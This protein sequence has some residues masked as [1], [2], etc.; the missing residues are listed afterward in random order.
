MIPQNLSIGQRGPALAQRQVGQTPDLSGQSALSS[1][2][3]EGTTGLYA[4][5]ADIERLV[6]IV[7]MHGVAYPALCR[8]AL[9]TLLDRTEALCALV[10]ASHFDDASVAPVHQ[11]F[12]AAYLAAQEQFRDYARWLLDYAVFLHD[13]LERVRPPAA[14][15]LRRH[16]DA[17]RTLI[18][19]SEAIADLSHT[20][21]LASRLNAIV[22]P[23]ESILREREG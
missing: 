23:A 15:R 18:L 20:V 16:L 13:Q 6:A 4:T 14:R 17:L 2:S 19:S 5:C 12:E 22:W 9:F 10:H 3:V 7:R 8:D 21:S 1:S 11:A